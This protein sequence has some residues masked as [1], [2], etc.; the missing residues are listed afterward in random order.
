MSTTNDRPT[1][2]EIV[3]ALVEMVKWKAKRE[4]RFDNRCTK[5]KWST[6]YHVYWLIRPTFEALVNLGKMEYTDE[7][8]EWA[9]LK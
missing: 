3:D 4:L 9:W 7:S 6:A 1:Y 2:E 8:R 5:I